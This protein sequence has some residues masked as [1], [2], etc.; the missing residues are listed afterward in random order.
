[1]NNTSKWAREPD[2]NELSSDNLHLTP[3]VPLADNVD[4]R[5]RESDPNE[6]GSKGLG[7]TFEGSAAGRHWTKCH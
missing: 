7:L 1:V 5:A 2:P 3:D 6:L 4:Q